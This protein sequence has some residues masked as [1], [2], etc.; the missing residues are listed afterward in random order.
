[1]YAAPWPLPSVLTEQEESELADRAKAVAIQG[2]NKVK[3]QADL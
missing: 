2:R 3:K 1:M